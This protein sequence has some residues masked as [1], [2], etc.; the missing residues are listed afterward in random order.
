MSHFGEVLTALAL[1]ISLYLRPFGFSVMTKYM[2]IVRPNQLSKMT[3]FVPLTLALQSEKSRAYPYPI[4]VPME[5]Q[6]E[7]RRRVQIYVSFRGQHP[8]GLDMCLWVPPHG[9]LKIISL[10]LFWV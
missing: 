6:H 5:T 4:C 8:L 10:A 3:Y 2:P 9:D 1:K 7:T